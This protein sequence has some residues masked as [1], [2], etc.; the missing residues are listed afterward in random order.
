VSQ[1]V[2][3]KAA[4]P[5]RAYVEAKLADETAIAS[6]RDA[7]YEETGVSGLY[8]KSD[9]H[10]TILPPFTIDKSATHV[11]NELLEDSALLGRKIPVKGVGVWPSLRNPRVI[12]LD[13]PVDIAV[14][15]ERLMNRL[16]DLGAVEME[17]PV[18]PHITLFKT[19]NGY[20]VEDHVRDAIRRAVWAN[21][22]EWTTEIE[23]VDLSVVAHLTIAPND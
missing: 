1:A 14:E 6:L 19:D 12:L 23:Y 3:H 7:L 2:P 21:R 10:L 18:C 8:R 22:D 4:R 13:T 20:E 16:R 15:R 9:P 5:V 17:E 11:V